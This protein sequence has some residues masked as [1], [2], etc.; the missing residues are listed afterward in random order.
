MLHPRSNHTTSTHTL[1]YK[2]NPVALSPAA[3]NLLGAWEE[4][5]PTASEQHHWPPQGPSM[6]PSATMRSLG[7]VSWSWWLKLTPPSLTITWERHH[8]TFSPRIQWLLPPFFLFSAAKWRYLP[9][10]KWFILGHFTEWAAVLYPH[11]LWSMSDT[12]AGS[13]PRCALR[14]SVPYLQC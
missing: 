7:K 1:W 5:R 10:I 13:R 6:S 12:A 3:V 11:S 4:N 14:H 9:S 8:Q 2:T